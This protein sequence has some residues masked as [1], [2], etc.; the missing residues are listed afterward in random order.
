MNQ[1]AKDCA[2]ELE[3]RMIA[4]EVFEGQVDCE[5][6]DQIK[7][8]YENSDKWVLEWIADPT[9]LISQVFSVCAAYSS[10]KPDY[11]TIGLIVKSIFDREVREA[12]KHIVESYD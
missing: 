9:D 2:A 10:K 4:Q 11:N 1:I 5:F 3:R 7:A 12:A 6:D 8:I